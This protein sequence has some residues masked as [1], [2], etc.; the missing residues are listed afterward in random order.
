VLDNVPWLFSAEMLKTAFQ[1]TCQSA[2]NA[3]LMKSGDFRDSFR[4]IAARKA[5]I[6]ITINAVDQCFDRAVELGAAVRLLFSP[7]RHIL[8]Y[9]GMQ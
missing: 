1:L 4:S 3:S 9:L 2:A 6:K 5:D 7:Q 8:T